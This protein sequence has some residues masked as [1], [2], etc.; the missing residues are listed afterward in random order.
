MSHPINPPFLYIF[1][2]S[3]S[4]Y[5]PKNYAKAEVKNYGG[6]ALKKVADLGKIKTPGPWILLSNS[7]FKDDM[8]PSSWW[9][10]LRLVIHSNSGYDALLGSQ[11]KLQQVP[12]LLGNEL[13]RDAV[14]EY[15]LQCLL[16]GVGEIPWKKAWD[17]SRQFPRK[18]IADL[19]ITV[20]GHGHIGAKLTAV[21]KSLGS[22]VS[23]FDPKFPA[24][25]ID[26]KKH[27]WKE[28]DAVVVCCALETSSTQLINQSLLKQ[29]KSEVMIINAARGQVICESDLLKFLNKNPQ[30]QA[31]LDVFEKEPANWNA[32]NQL[33][34]GQV[35]LS[36]HVAGVYDELAAK[37]LQFEK[38]IL[39][40]YFS[41]A[42][43]PF[44]KKYKQILWQKN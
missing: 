25:S 37:S 28:Q 15:Y 7:H 12:V 30:A 43:K 14:V 22:H 32:W 11:K 35:H 16:K 3:Y 34:T 26:W 41:L 10:E 6:L 31:F 17:G 20:I 38:N 33:A 8:I 40:D 24:F 21:L 9:P 44:L 2:P 36:S 4:T 18:L 42:Q 39:T 1:R 13:R 23:V 27:S 19:N 5:W 29:L